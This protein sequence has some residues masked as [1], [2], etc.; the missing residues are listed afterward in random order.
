M[1]TKHQKNNKER[2]NERVHAFYKELK[3]LG[4]ESFF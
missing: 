4:L 2:Q 3:K 1:K